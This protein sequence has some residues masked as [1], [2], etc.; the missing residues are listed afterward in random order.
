MVQRMSTPVG[1]PASSEGGAPMPPDTK[2]QEREA[3]LGA[4]TAGEPVISVRHL[5]KVFGP[6]AAERA[7]VTGAGRAA[8]QGAEGADRLRRRRL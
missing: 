2:D 1:V 3:G 4:G 8:P 7:G 6:K 5:W